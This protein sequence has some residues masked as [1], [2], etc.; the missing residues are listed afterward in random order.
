MVDEVCAQ[1]RQEGLQLACEP[2]VLTGSPAELIVETAGD[3]EVDMILMGRRG[4]SFRARM[5]MG[6]VTEKVIGRAHCSP[7]WS[8][9]SSCCWGWLNSAVSSI[10]SRIR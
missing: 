4:K 5:L 7:C 10:S 8:D 2:L 6:R 3:R 9:S 1:C